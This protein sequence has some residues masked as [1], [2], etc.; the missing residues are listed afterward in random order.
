[1]ILAA[2]GESRAG[3]PVP[4]ADAHAHGRS[5]TRELRRCTLHYLYG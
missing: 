4:L 2:V 5:N 1:M 3:M